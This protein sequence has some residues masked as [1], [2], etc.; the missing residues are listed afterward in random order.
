MPNESGLN[1]QENRHDDEEIDELVIPELLRG[2]Y[3][4][5]NNKIKRPST[6]DSSSDGEVPALV[7]PE[8]G[9]P[10]NLVTNILD[11]DED[12]DNT[13]RK[14][15]GWYGQLN[16]YS[17]VF[18]FFV[19]DMKDTESQYGWWIIM[20]SSLTSFITLFTME[21]FTLSTTH[22]S[23][24][25]WCKN[26]V[27]SILTILTT[28]IASWVKKKGYVKRIQDIDKRIARLEKFLGVLDFQI[29]LV[30]PK[31]REDYLE[32]I[33]K[34]REEHNELSIHT[35]L[36]SPAEFSY[37]VYM[38]TRYNTPVI[39][40]AWPWYNTTTLRPQK[41][42]AQNIIN[43]YE[44]QYGWCAWLKMCMSCSWDSIDDFNPLLKEDKID[45]L[46]WMCE[47]DRNKRL[48]RMSPELR[49]ETMAAL[50]PRKLQ[51]KK[52]SNNKHCNG[53]ESNSDTDTSSSNRLQIDIHE[54]EDD[55]SSNS[56]Q[57]PI[58]ERGL[59]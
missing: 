39:Q 19:Q 20:I 41:N 8:I 54:K 43:I 56:S 36:I 4:P 35:S 28:L 14:V 27:I 46:V 34:H 48:N 57:S 3:I 13:W 59:S 23:Y 37:T 21:P 50:S 42:F 47:K 16:F 9:K 11:Y 12:F 30:P 18:Q 10:N 55:I 24:Y 49:A 45:A 6:G 51:N 40:G 38:I 7:I 32:F 2:S 58:M 52:S 15:R 17:K 53:I 26:I 1:L 44:A 22:D 5:G 31:N 33:T 25:E 29:R